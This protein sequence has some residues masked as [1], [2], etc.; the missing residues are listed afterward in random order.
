MRGWTKW[1][2]I[3]VIVAV[4]IGVIT[5]QQMDKKT[6]EQKS[7]APGMGAQ[8]RTGDLG[9]SGGH[10]CHSNHCHHAHRANP[11]VKGRFQRWLNDDGSW[12]MRRDP[13]ESAKDDGFKCQGANVQLV[14]HTQTMRQYVIY[15]FFS[16]DGYNPLKHD[17]VVSDWGTHDV[18]LNEHLQHVG[19]GY[20]QGDGFD[21]TT[22]KIH[23]ELDAL[24]ETPENKRDS[25][26]HI[27]HARLT[28]LL[29]QRAPEGGNGP[30]DETSLAPPGTSFVLTWTATYTGSKSFRPTAFFSKFTLEIVPK[31]DYP[32]VT[33][34]TGSSGEDKFILQGPDEGI[35]RWSRFMFASKITDDESGQV[36]QKGKHGDT[37]I[38][39]DHMFGYTEIE[40]SR[41]QDQA[42]EVIVP[43]DA[44][45]TIVDSIDL[46]DVVTGKRTPVSGVKMQRVLTGNVNYEAKWVDSNWRCP[47]RKATILDCPNGVI[48]ASDEYDAPET[49]DF[50]Q[51]WGL[52][53]TMVRVQCYMGK[54]AKKISIPFN[55]RPTLT[56]Y[57]EFKF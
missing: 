38:Y 55:Q 10:M 39:D 42:L 9:P 26:Y 11:L 5:F 12:T 54:Y 46:V 23:E 36:M 3:L 16:S 2:L 40:A 30:F 47:G 43:I 20:T 19:P 24:Q 18:E 4:A 32:R 17:V 44:S 7:G 37:I 29:R 49:A 15:L 53:S 13:E 35:H 6:T 50:G 25:S 41:F 57:L 14:S 56:S 45:H 8:T 27:K 33:R 52:G 28:Q 34:F 1:V 31:M 48:S 22:D 21:M 51:C